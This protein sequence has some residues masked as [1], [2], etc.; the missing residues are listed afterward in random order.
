M[1]VLIENLQFS[2]IWSTIMQVI[3]RTK[4]APTRAALIKANVLG[5]LVHFIAVNIGVY[6]VHTWF[7]PH[8]SSAID[9]LFGRASAPPEASR[10]KN[11]RLARSF[12]ACRCRNACTL[13]AMTKRQ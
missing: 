4:E 10:S 8:I 1:D 9:R 6:V 5:W 7:E 13:G 12:A 11:Q 3:Y 2:L